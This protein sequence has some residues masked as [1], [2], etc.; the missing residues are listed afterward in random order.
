MQEYK[1]DEQATANQTYDSEL[2]YWI[3]ENQTSYLLWFTRYM[4]K[5]F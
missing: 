2:A 1:A 3:I 5:I 4:L